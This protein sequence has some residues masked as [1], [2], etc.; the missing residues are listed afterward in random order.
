MSKETPFIG[1]RDRKITISRT[2]AVVNE[3]SE[4]VD[5]MVTVSEPWA[6]MKDTSGGQEIDGKV[7][8]VVNRSY[9]VLRIPAIVNDAW[10]MRL[11]DGATEFEITHV[12]EIGRTHL[13]LI[14]QANE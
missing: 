8:T 6:Y 3:I 12:K 4:H 5:T 13:E 11:T 10:K 1:Q 14:V 2:V 7:V 9:T